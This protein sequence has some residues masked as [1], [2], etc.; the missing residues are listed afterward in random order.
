M[1][2]G[3]LSEK[4]KFKYFDLNFDP[5]YTILHNKKYM[6]SKLFQG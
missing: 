4:F 1:P 6:K 5:A 3:I 2:D